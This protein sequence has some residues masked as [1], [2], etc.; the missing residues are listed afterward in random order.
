M[1]PL[2]WVQA[3]DEVTALFGGELLCAL[4]LILIEEE[5]SNEEACSCIEAEDGE[6]GKECKLV[7]AHVPYLIDEM[8]EYFLALNSL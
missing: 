8:E 2:L 1:L 6:C 5:G 3:T 7:V 4:V